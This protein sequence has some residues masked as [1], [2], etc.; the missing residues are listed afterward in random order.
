MDSTGWLGKDAYDKK[1]STKKETG[2]KVFI[3]FP[4]KLSQNAYQQ[5]TSQVG[6]NKRIHTV[7]YKWSYDCF[8]Q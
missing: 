1:K 5:L 6:E 8:M 7:P 2:T 3:N 4:I